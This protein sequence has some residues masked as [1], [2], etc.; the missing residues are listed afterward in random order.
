MKRLRSRGR[1]ALVAAAAMCAVVAQPGASGGPVPT[2]LPGLSGTAA[3]AEGPTAYEFD[4]DAGPLEGGT[5]TGDAGELDEG[6]AYRASI[7]PGKKLFYQLDLDDAENA[8]VSATAVPELESSVD[9]GDKITVTM[10]DGDGK[11]CDS[12]Q[13]RVLPTGDYPQPLTAYVSRTLTGKEYGPCRKAGTYYVIVERESKA[14]SSQEPWD[15]ELR[16]LSE[17]PVKAGGSTEAPEDWSSA[18]PGPPSGASE[19]RAGGA[20]FSAATSLGDGEWTAEIDPG[21]SLFYRVPVD[22]GQQLFAA[23]E[24]GGSDGRG[25]VT[26]A[27]SLAVY[28]PARGLVDSTDTMSYNGEPKWM[29][30]DPA[31]PVHYANRFSSAPDKKAMRFAGWYYLR[32]SLNPEVGGKFGR[33]PYDLTVRVNVEGKAVDGPEYD[34]PA[35]EFNVSDENR[36]QAGGGN[37]ANED[38]GTMTLVAAGGIGTGTVLVLGLGGWALLARR[39]GAGR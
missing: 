13:A 31:P 6:S 25:I 20:G 4:K 18:S 21:E 39:W 7:E 30:T 9:Y 2:G 38:S 8:Y 5:G 34:G 36:D 23:A 32:V 14:T 33:E 29:S 37:P 15:L 26:G 12:E 11:D 1:V 16:F 10:Q 35:E 28:N 17:P 24:L 27:M 22:W 19:P 3:A